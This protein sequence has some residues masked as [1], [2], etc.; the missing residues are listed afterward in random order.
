MPIPAR[1]MV[2]CRGKVMARDVVIAPNTKQ[3]LIS[4]YDEMKCPVRQRG[5]KHNVLNKATYPAVLPPIIRAHIAMHQV[6]R[7]R[8]I[9]DAIAR[10]SNTPHCSYSI[11][12]RIMGNMERFDEIPVVRTKGADVPV[13][14]SKKSE[15]NTLPFI[16]NPDSQK[17]ART[18]PALPNTNIK[19][20][21]AMEID[22]RLSL[23]MTKAQTMRNVQLKKNNGFTLGIPAL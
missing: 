13:Q 10:A 11:R 17:L 4:G 8:E 19:N 12:G 2:L 20:S 16:Q 1:A 22:I 3:R 18:D 21:S 9:I 15:C 5:P 14:Y 6:L 7:D 23:G